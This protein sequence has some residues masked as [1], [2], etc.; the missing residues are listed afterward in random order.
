MT[1][2]RQ[3]QMPQQV[4]AVGFSAWKRRHIRAFLPESTLHFVDT[5]REVP[6]RAAL[7][8]WGNQKAECAAQ[9]T[10]RVEDGFLRSVGL[11]ADLIAPLSYCFDRSGV[12]YDASRPSDLETILRES[13][14]SEAI[15]ARSQAL[16]TRIVALGLTKYNVGVRSWRRPARAQEVILVPGQVESDASIQGGCGALRSNM[17][18]LQKVRTQHPYAHVIYKPHP[19]VVAGLRRWGEAEQEAQRYCDTVVTDV[20]LQ[21]VLEQVDAV[22]VLT[23][24][25]GFEA[26]LRG[27]PVTCHG[28]PF[29]SGWGLTTDLLPIAR[30]QRNLSLDALVAGALILYPRYVHPKTRRL[31]SVEEA[32]TALD[33][34]Y[35]RRRA[36]HLPLWRRAFRMVLRQVVGVR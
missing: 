8:L 2:N 12:Y 19:D 17:A 21:D 35:G 13:V 16:R 30:R 22:H 26:L 7:L 14:F 18:L 25:A 4:Y 34:Q 9:H 15:L 33:A 6:A 3:T 5:Q 29:Y 10:I 24:G 28:A 27:K 36:Y 31:C 20:R 1:I 32:V 11:G 23:S